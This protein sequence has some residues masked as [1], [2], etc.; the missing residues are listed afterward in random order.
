MRKGFFCKTEVE[1]KIRK[2]S[3]NYDKVDYFQVAKKREYA[4]DKD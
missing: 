4:R 2:L 3:E 1:F